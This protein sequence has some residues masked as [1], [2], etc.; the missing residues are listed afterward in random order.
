MQADNTPSFFPH[1]QRIHLA[2]ILRAAKSFHF[3][4]FLGGG[5]VSSSTLPTSN[6]PIPQVKAAGV[7]SEHSSHTLAALTQKLIPKLTPRG[8]FLPGFSSSEFFVFCFLFFFSFFLKEK[9][10]SYHFFRGLFEA[11]MY[12][13]TG[14]RQHHASGAPR[15]GME[16]L[17]AWSPSQQRLQRDEL[18]EYASKINY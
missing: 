11:F 9:S 18:W 1:R 5:T 16:R 10:L 17:L 8:P 3:G 2:L 7:Q 12:E 14:N 13:V 6:K 15:S 4:L